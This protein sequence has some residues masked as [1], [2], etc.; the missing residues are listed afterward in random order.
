MSGGISLVT[1]RLFVR[2]VGPVAEWY[3][4]LFEVAPCES[5]EAFVSFDLNGSAQGAG[6]RLDISLADEKSPSGAGGCIG[7][8]LVAD[9]DTLLGRV[10]ALGGEIYR[11]PL[12]VDEIGRTIVQIKDPFGHIMGFEADFASHKGPA[13]I[14]EPSGMESTNS[15]VRVEVVGHTGPDFEDWLSMRSQLWPHHDLAWHRADL[16]GSLRD[17]KSIQGFVAYAPGGKT[18]TPVGFAEITI[19][20]FANGCQSRPVCFLEGVFVLPQTRRKGV[21]RKL[22]HSVETWAKSQGFHEIGSD[23]LMNN[24]ESL[25]AHQ[26]WGFSEMERVVYF[27]KELRSER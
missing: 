4:R 15:D 12:R 14:Q 3:E 18:S 6:A 1:L 10:K 22:I 26:R 23:A 7:Y 8:W 25:Q 2:E 5:L 17:P 27:R 21:G 24:T 11:G 13:D 16:E 9:L 19:R 20:P